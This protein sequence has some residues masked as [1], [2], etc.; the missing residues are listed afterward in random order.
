M[1]RIKKIEELQALLNATCWRSD[2]DCY[3]DRDFN[4]ITLQREEKVI[5]IDGWYIRFTDIYTDLEN[6]YQRDANGD[7]FVIC[8]LG[9]FDGYHEK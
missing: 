9:G 5:I 6:V 7:Y 8:K 3:R 1:T 4:K 2:V